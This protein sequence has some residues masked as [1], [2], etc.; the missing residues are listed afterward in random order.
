MQNQ[1]TASSESQGIYV[2]QPYDASA[3]TETPTSEKT[4][5]TMVEYENKKYYVAPY[6]KKSVFEQW[7]YI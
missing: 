3:S 2:Y 7:F 1:S 6:P 4:E 5:G